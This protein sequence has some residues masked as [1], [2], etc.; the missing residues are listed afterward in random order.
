[1]DTPCIPGKNIFALAILIIP[2]LYSSIFFK[3]TGHEH[4]LWTDVYV[5]FSVSLAFFVITFLV[6]NSNIFLSN[7]I[8]DFLGKISYSLYLLHSPILE[9]F[10]K[11]VNKQ[12][13]E[14]QKG[15]F[16]LIF[17]VTSIIISYLSYMIIEK[18]LQKAIR[19][20][21]PR[22]LMRKLPA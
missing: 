10:T 12:S 3:L 17:A 9:Q 19:S 16:L 14:S 13:D 21:I 20:I 22:Y 15:L 11:I 2:F 6:P 7:R 5:L 18:P 4:K 8:G 1:M